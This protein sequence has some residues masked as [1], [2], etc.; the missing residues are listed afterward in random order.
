MEVT[1]EIYAWLV[2]IKIMDQNKSIKMRPD[3]KIMIP[4]NIVKIMME[5]FLFDRILNNLEEGYNKFYKIKLN[6]TD[7]LKDLNLE[8]PE[9]KDSLPLNLRNSNW[10]IITDVL[11]NFG[12]EISKRKIEKI[13]SGNIHE[14]HEL[15]NTLYSLSCELS[16]KSL[17]YSTTLDTSSIAKNKSNVKSQSITQVNQSQFKNSNYHNG[18]SLNNSIHKSQSI[19]NTSNINNE[20]IDLNRFDA[21]KDYSNCNS[22]LEF[23]IISLCKIFSMKPRQ[24]IALLSDNRKY[25]RHICN[26]GIKGDFDKISQWYY[27]ISTNIKTFTNLL[28]TWNNGRAVGYATISVGLYSKNYNIAMK[29]YNLLAQLLIDIGTDWDWFSNEGILAI[30]FCINKHEE[31]RV[32]MINLIY[33]FSRKNLK[34]LN[35]IMD[36]RLIV[37]NNSHKL[38]QFLSSIVNC[39]KSA[40]NLIYIKLK[41]YLLNSLLKERKDISAAVSILSDAWINFY[42]LDRHFTNS[43]VNYIK[44]GVR[45]IFNQNIKINEDANS[46]NDSNNDSNNTLIN[47]VKKSVSTCSVINLFR[48]RRRFR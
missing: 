32:N 20:T 42:P 2:N 35:D 18:M 15:L 24:S 25:L 45:T 21:N 22:P 29:A 11:T 10:S 33:D 13:T 39:L 37:E 43:I 44:N 31:L 19:Y 14:L 1:P 16:R 23:L 34:E 4:D 41:E 7:R 17:D 8:R 38:L 27:E 12:I 36:S 5:G 28:R 26:K 40:D 46:N 6:Y 9:G 3:G 48:V 30:V 47:S